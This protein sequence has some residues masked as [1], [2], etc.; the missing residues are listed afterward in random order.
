MELNIREET[1]IKKLTKG[2]SITKWSEAYVKITLTARDVEDW[3]GWCD[4]VQVLKYIIWAAKSRINSLDDMGW[5]SHED[6]VK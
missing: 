1:D 4:D 3:I 5:K 2:E 6:Y